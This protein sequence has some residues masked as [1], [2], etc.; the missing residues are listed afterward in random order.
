MSRRWG[1][2]GLMLTTRCQ[3]RRI[4]TFQVVWN[5]NDPSEVAV[6]TSAT[7]TDRSACLKSVMA[8][9]HRGIETPCADP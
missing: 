8:R 9:N 3:Y 7:A 2:A 1:G 5:I 4:S 6:S